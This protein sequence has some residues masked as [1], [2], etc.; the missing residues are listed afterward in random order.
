M[1]EVPPRGAEE[2]EARHIARLPPR[3]R[4]EPPVPAEAEI[5]KGLEADE[6]DVPHAGERGSR[7]ITVVAGG[8]A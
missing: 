1:E 4:A 2:L 5:E 6:V 8:P 7:R 3:E